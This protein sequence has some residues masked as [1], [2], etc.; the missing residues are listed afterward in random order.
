M[1]G[2][3]IVASFL[4]SVTEALVK[5]KVWNRNWNPAVFMCAYDLRGIGAI[6]TTFGKSY[7]TIVCI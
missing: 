4:V 3:Y 1:V 5:V 6:E 7:L 2:F